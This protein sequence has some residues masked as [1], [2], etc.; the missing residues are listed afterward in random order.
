MHG[1]HLFLCSIKSCLAIAVQEFRINACACDFNW[2]CILRQEFNITQT[3]LE[4]RFFFVVIS[5]YRFLFSTPIVAVTAETDL[6]SWAECL[7]NEL[8]A[9]FLKT[10]YRDQILFMWTVY[11]QFHLCTNRTIISLCKHSDK[12]D[13][14]I[15]F[16]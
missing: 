2:T 1:F 15:V 3:Y 7:C 9:C 16:G 11:E 8:L 14:N 13:I 12:W 6:D 5:W 10:C 4:R